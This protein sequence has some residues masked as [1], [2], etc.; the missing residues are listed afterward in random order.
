MKE[1]QL[2]K[3]N[4]I[5]QMLSALDTTLEENVINSIHVY[6]ELKKEFEEL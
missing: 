3:A 6:I 5:S 1:K 4:E 2:L